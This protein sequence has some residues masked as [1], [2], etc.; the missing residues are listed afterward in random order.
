MTTQA[1]IESGRAQFALEAVQRIV[2]SADA[3]KKKQYKAYARKFPTLVLT[4]GLAA[5]VAFAKEKHGAWDNIYEDTAAWLVEKEFFAPPTTLEGYVCSL[6]SDSYRIATKEVLALFSWLR[7]F[8]GG[9]IEG[10]APN[11]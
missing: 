8:A 5:A 1:T 11:D 4:N 6:D 2:A 3:D 9:L 10:E 7:R